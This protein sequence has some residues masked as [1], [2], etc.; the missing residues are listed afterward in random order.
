MDAAKPRV[1]NR[2]GGERLGDGKRGERSLQ[3]RSH[4]TLFPPLLFTS[5]ACR[6]LVTILLSP[7]IHCC[8]LVCPVTPQTHKRVAARHQQMFN[9]HTFC[10]PH[11]VNMSGRQQAPVL[12]AKK[13]TML[14]FILGPLSWISEMTLYTFLRMAYWNSSWN[15]LESCSRSHLNLYGLFASVYLCPV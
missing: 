13:T 14:L 6:P 15:V 12:A 9:W 7:S 4:H 5:T 8:W 11:G 1:R 2:E 3:F 10:R